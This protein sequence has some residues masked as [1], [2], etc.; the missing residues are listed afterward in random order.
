[1]LAGISPVV[2]TLFMHWLRKHN[3]CG[4]VATTCHVFQVI[5]PVPSKTKALVPVYRATPPCLT[6]QRLGLRIMCT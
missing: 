1:M 3:P 5:D 2:V 4:F 6:L